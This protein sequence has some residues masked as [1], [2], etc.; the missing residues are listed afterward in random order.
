VVQFIKIGQ[1]KCDLSIQVTAWATQH[2]T[3]KPV[4]RGH[5]GDEEKNGL[6]R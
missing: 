2:N 6:S 3:A 5:S 1:E 4:L